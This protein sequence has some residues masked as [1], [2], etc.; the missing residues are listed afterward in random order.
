MEARLQK[1]ISSYGAASRRQAEKMILDGRV[2]VNGRTASLGDVADDEVD[3]ITI[4]GKKLISR[5]SY[6]YLILNKPR[7]YVTTLRDERGRKSVS[8]LVKDCGA[9]V[10]PVGR[11]DQYSEGLLLLTNDGE[12]TNKLTHPKGEIKKIYHV[13]VNGYYDAAL[14]KLRA[15]IEI[16]GRKTIPANVRVLAVKG[17]STMLEFTL[18]EGRNRQI[19][20][21]CE[22]AEIRVT[23]LKRVQEGC[24]SLGDLPVGKWRIL[25]E[26]EIEELYREAGLVYG[27]QP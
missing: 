21:L 17:E 11:L 7:G 2:A 8:D 18:F 16:D 24:V 9:R 5:P 1:I 6:L 26:G 19:R 4:D 10:Y 27:L 13:W 25:T 14:V 22:Y 23:R 12:L 3:E 15:S 20:R